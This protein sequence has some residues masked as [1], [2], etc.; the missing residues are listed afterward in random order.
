[1]IL[2]LI[3]NHHGEEAPQTDLKIG[4]DLVAGMVTLEVVLIETVTIE[5]GLVAEIQTAGLI[6]GTTIVEGMAVMK[7]KI[8]EEWIVRQILPQRG[9]VTLQRLEREKQRMIEGRKRDRP[10]MMIMHGGEHVKKWQTVLDLLTPE[11]R[12]LGEVRDNISHPKTFHKMTAESTP[13]F[14]HYNVFSSIV[15]QFWM[16][17]I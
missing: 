5:E 9:G 1:M 10:Q 12:N 15:R 8:E 17:C 13:P 7:V 2:Q 6:E 14:A 4:E 11:Q 3:R 16:L